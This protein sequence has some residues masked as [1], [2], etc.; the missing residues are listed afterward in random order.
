MPTLLNSA[1]LQKYYIMLSEWETTVEIF[2]ESFCTKRIEMG[3]LVNGEYTFNMN[4]SEPS[5]SIP[6]R[7]SFLL[8]LSREDLILLHHSSA[9]P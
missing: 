2:E 7:F 3:Y 1:E 9:L 5:Q 8:D 6:A 4:R